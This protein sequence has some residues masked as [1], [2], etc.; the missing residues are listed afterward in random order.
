DST[1]YFMRARYYDAEIGRFLSEDPI[2]STN[3]YPYA[4]N[5]PMMGI[6]PKGTFS[7]NPE[8]FIELVSTGAERLN[9]GLSSTPYNPA[10]LRSAINVGPSQAERSKNAA[11]I[12]ASGSG[13]WEA[14]KLVVKQKAAETV[15]AVAGAS[16]AT[17]I[18]GTA[19]VTATALA[20]WDVKIM[21]DAA[22]DN[23]SNGKINWDKWGEQVDN[24]GGYMW[25]ASQY[26]KIG[27]RLSKAKV[28]D[29]RS[30]NP[31]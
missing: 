16:A 13:A 11:S 26:L 1:L 31:F 25:Q 24:N 28:F 22:N 8:A 7:G 17:I 3:L 6:D 27:Q 14:S 4:D 10:I 20:G 2:W 19:L 23:Q 18:A 29:L 21:L 5:N 15:T 9:S 12:L 30:W